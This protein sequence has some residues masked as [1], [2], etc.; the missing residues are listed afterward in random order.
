M[1]IS[2]AQRQQLVS[3][4]LASCTDDREWLRDRVPLYWAQFA[5]RD[6]VIPFLT[7]Q[8]VKRRL[9]QVLLGPLRT[10]YDG[11]TAD[12]SLKEHQQ[13]DT[14][15]AII[16]DATAEIIRLETKAAR[17]RGGT[18]QP[19]VRPVPQQYPVLPDHDERAVIAY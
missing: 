2:V 10:V 11:S 1:A 7:D 8:Y 9:A 19:F 15:D 4:D 17:S 13:I 16:K 5:D 3:D 6:Q 14:L 18:S 12:E